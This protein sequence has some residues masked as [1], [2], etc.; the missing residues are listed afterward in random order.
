MKKTLYGTI[1]GISPNAAGGMD[2]TLS[3]ENLD[4]N[5]AYTI[6]YTIDRGASWHDSGQITKMTNLPLFAASNGIMWRL[7]SQ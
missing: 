2:I 3:F 7:N 1:T 4:V 5:A 6:Q